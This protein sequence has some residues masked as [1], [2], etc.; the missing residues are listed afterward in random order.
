MVGICTALAPADA[1]ADPKPLLAVMDT[2]P[3][4]SAELLSLAG[5]LSNYYHQP[6]GEVFAILLPAAARQGASRRRTRTRIWSPLPGLDIATALQALHRA[7]RQRALLE[8]LSTQPLTTHGAILAAG[9]T[10][11]QLNALAERHFIHA[12][13]VDTPPP[14]VANITGPMLGEEQAAAVRTVSAS[15]GTFQAFVLDGITGSGKTEVYLRLIEQVVRSGGQALLLVPEIGLTPQTLARVQQRFPATVAMHSGLSDSERWSAWLACQ[16]GSA[17]VLV[18]TRSAVFTQFQDLRLIVVDEEHDASFKQQDSLRYSAR[19]VAVVRARNLDIPVLLGSATPSLESL[20]NVQ[21]GRYRHLVLSR[22]PGSA[23]PP[24][25]HILDIR[26]HTLDEG[27]SQDMIRVMQRHLDAGGQVLTYVNRRGFSPVLLCTVC[28]WT[29]NCPRCESRLTLHRQPAG[30]QCHHCGLQRSTPHQCDNGH[31]TLL[32]VGAGTQRTESAL[33]RLFP[34][35]PVLRID[36]DTTRSQQRFEV[37]LEQIAR[38]A[39]LI[40]V[41]TQMLAKGHHFPGVTL[42]AIVNADGGFLSSDF[43][44]P[45]RTAQ[46]IMQVAGRAGREA[47]RGEVWIQTLQPDHPTLMTLVSEGYGAFARQELANR[48]RAA[49]PPATRMAL[50]RADALRQA[51]ATTFLTTL[52]ATIGTQVQALGPAPAPIQRIAHRH[53]QQLLL[54]ATGRAELQRL[55]LRIRETRPPAGV[56]WSID[57]DPYDG[58]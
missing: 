31:T 53:R 16:D 39:P 32:P 25:F 12:T 23:E 15:L 38:G 3:L 47:R 11:P 40:L 24:S 34:D 44:A 14:P 4:V 52:K 45:E 20:A 19:D 36:R 22:R 54:L 2:T 9:F 35:I 49:L 17:S 1:H 30:L 55:C 46:T 29:A 41:G 8:F 21:A 51:D 42:V 57:I 6:L 56:R 5:W 48:Q 28:G 26:G 37:Q 27:L 33:E 58:A 18:G 13:E 7:P 10:G 43:R 50:I